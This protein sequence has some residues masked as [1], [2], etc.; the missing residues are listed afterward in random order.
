MALSRYG[1]PSRIV[2]D[3]YRHSALVEGLTKAE[4]PFVPLVTRRGGFGDGTE[5]LS[6]FRKAC[7]SDPPLVFPE[8]SLLLRSSLAAGRTASDAS[9]N[10]KLGKTIFGM[11]DA[12]SAAILAVSSGTRK[13]TQTPQGSVFQ[14]MK[15]SLKPLFRSKRWERTRRAVKKRD[16]Y[17]CTRCGK[18]GRL[19][20]HHIKKACDFPDLFFSLD[21]LIALCRS[22]HIELTRKENEADLPPQT[23]E[24][25]AF[26][27]ELI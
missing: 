12:L 22:C 9:G 27:S 17:R 26:V 2:C 14:S 4:I 23:R 13:P 21:N 1:K 16:K 6:Q 11:D 20:V 15:K 19:E 10:Q 18:A 7:L 8:V 5:D 25:R 24:W 3:K